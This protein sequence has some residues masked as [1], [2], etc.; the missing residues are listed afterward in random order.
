MIRTRP[1]LPPLPPHV[2]PLHDRIATAAK[3]SHVVIIAH[4]CMGVLMAVRRIAH[5]WP[6]PT[7]PAA[8]WVA[9]AIQYWAQGGPGVAAEIRFRDEHPTELD[10]ARLA[11]WTP[12]IVDAAPA[13]MPH[14]TVSAAGLLGGG[15]PVRPGEATLAHGGVLYLDELPEFS[16]RCVEGLREPLDCGHVEIY[17]AS[18]RQILPARFRLIASAMPCPCGFRGHAERGCICGPSIVQRYRA[19]MA[20]I[21]GRPDVIT[22]DLTGGE[23]AA[24]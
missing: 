9:A 7:G 13:R 6:R 15:T 24:R 2:Q 20:P 10:T 21:T 12:E 4:P 17:R 8:R 23:H 3:A 22:I 5:A 1:P 11:S 19:R 16:R 18:G 14:H